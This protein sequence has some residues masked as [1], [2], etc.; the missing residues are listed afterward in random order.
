MSAIEV[1]EASIWIHELHVDNRDVAKY[2]DALPDDQHEQALSDAI[3]VGAFCLERA[4]AGQSLDFVRREIESLLSRVKDALKVLP[5]ETKRQVS[6]TIGAGEGQVLAPIITLVH[7]VKT[8]A[9][10]KIENI[11]NLLQAEVNPATESSSLGKALRALRDLLDPK[12]TDS[13]QGALDAAVRQVTAESGSL[14]KAVHAVVSEA[15]KPLRQELSE[16]AREVHGKEAAA[17]ALEQTTLKGMSYEEEVLHAVKT[18]AHWHAAEVHHVGAD[19]QPGD[20]LVVFQGPDENG[21]GLRL[22]VEA[23]DRQSS[24]GRQAISNCMNE[25]MAKRGANTAIY[26]AKTRTGLAKEIGEWAEGNCEAGRWVAC[27]HEH[28]ITGLR[29]LVAQERLQ[30]LRAAAPAVDASSI[31]SQVQRIRTSLGRLK[32]IKTKIT[33]IRDG[34]DSIESEVALLRNDVN[35]ALTEIEDA[36]KIGR[37]ESYAN[38]RDGNRQAAGELLAS[39]A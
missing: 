20:I 12:R 24:H 37:K 33:T 34:A 4:R 39:P 11:R 19:N 7:E 21:D 15:V 25:A 17:A 16:L 31:E 3:K 1:L 14:A 22:I 36:L 32:N 28:L 38:A 9:S 8:A 10:E 35:G 2:L 6:A 30:Q 29:F 5:E 26:V 13:V 23:R 27:T 18:W